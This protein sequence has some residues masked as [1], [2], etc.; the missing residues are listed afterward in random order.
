MKT[1]KFLFLL[2]SVALV[3]SFIPGSSR[4]EVSGEKGRPAEYVGGVKFG[5]ESWDQCEF[6]ISIEKVTFLLT[7]FGNKYKVIRVRIVNSSTNSIQLSSENDSIVLKTPGGEDV[8]GLFKLQR[9]DAPLWD[10][11]DSEMRETLAYPQI[12]RAGRE[13]N[14]TGYSHQEVIYFF[15]FFPNDKVTQLPK[16]FYYKINSLPEPIEIRSR[17]T[18][19]RD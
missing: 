4:C 17:K 11:L 9:Q 12:I 13:G 1:F 3:I 14:T 6:S 8:R 2:V 10:S 18:M 15:V 7:A 5:I 16:S 19:T